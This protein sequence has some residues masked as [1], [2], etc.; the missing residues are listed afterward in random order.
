MDLELWRHVK[1]LAADAW[2]RPPADRA[3]YLAARCGGDDA[4]RDEVLSLLDAMERAG[5]GLDTPALGATTVAQM[6]RVVDAHRSV[7]IGERVGPWTLVR[8]VGQGGMGTV[9]LA[10][11]AD[12]EFAQR[13]AVK[14][15]RGGAADDLLVRRF[16]DERRILAALEHPH[17]A[18]L[19]DGGATPHGLPYVVMEYVEG[20]PIDLYC[21]QHALDLR[22]RSTCSGVCAWR[23]TTRT[24]IWSCTA[25][26]RRRTSS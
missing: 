11:R 8:E 23:W 17:I 19:I 6:A 26:S 15:V 21:E 9:Y 12:A 22:R 7:L 14:I 18:R 13:A 5:D 25:T 4:L 3:D 20:L 1:T 2:E 10:E 24:S 16:R